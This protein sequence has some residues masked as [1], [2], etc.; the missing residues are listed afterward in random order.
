MAIHA[1]RYVPRFIVSRSNWTPN[2]NIINYFA[3][4]ITN[5][6]IFGKKSVVHQ[7]ILTK[8][9]ESTPA[10]ILNQADRTCKIAK[11][12]I[13][14]DIIMAEHDVI[15]IFQAPTHRSLITAYQSCLFDI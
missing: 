4:K 14:L 10:N 11:Y 1:T 7:R 6:S 9:S 3:A 13:Y 5:R 8:L 15:N 12:S 2:A